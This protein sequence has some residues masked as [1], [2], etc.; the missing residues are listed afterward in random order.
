[1]AFDIE[2]IKKHPYATGAI[3]IVG[4]VAVFYLMSS[5]QSSGAATGST[6]GTD[7]TAAIANADAQLA[8]V[9]AA[10]AVQTNAQQVTMQQ[11][12]L[13]ADVANNQTEASLQANNVNTAA[14]LAAT[15]AQIQASTQQNQ[16]S[17]N[18]QLAENAD[19]LSAQTVQ[20]G[21]ELTYASNI[22]SMQDAVLEDQIN[23]GVIENAN[24]NATALA[25][26]EA[27]IDYQT[28]LAG[29]QAAVASQGVTAAETVQQQQL[30]NQYSLSQQTLDMV[31]QAGLNH[32]TESLENDLTGVIGEALG[33]PGTA[34]AAVSGN[35][36][37]A[38]ASS[39]A[40][41]SIINSIT[42]GATKVATSL[43]A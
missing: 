3:V 38:A 14:T 22:Q 7:D 27:T 30:S 23:S 8:Q 15:L 18:A 36:Q 28:T 37:A 32:G 12:Q 1:M 13:E 21:N 4:G 39:A 2:L 6:A 20:Q 33:Q 31:Q 25:G 43:F 9:Q 40:T 19:T 11:N 5:G 17:L 26:T 29:Y 34:T 42:G 41:A 24:N 10:A 16:D 35:S